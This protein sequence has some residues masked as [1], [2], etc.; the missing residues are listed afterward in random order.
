MRRVARTEHRRQHGAVKVREDVHRRLVVELV[1]GDRR[2]R[3]RRSG[4]GGR[5]VW[6]S[7]VG[8]GVVVVGE[9]VRQGLH[10][11]AAAPLQVVT[12]GQG[13]HLE[14]GAG[15][16]QNFLTDDSTGGGG[17]VFDW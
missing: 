5:G 14:A 12:P 2:G 1:P 3:C 9:V 7:G 6:T 13:Q 16:L 15:V 8:H 11:V 4:T 10:H 17:G